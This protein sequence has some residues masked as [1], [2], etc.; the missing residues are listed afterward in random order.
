MHIKVWVPE[1]PVSG[2]VTSDESTSLNFSVLSNT[3]YICAPYGD[4]LA[5]GYRGFSSPSKDS[6]HHKPEYLQRYPS[7]PPALPTLH[8]PFLLARLW[9]RP[10][11]LLPHMPI[12]TAVSFLLSL[13]ELARHNIILDWS[14]LKAKELCLSHPLPLWT[15]DPV[16]CFSCVCSVPLRPTRM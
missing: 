4:R 8:I 9:L 12:Q 6:L 3:N 2:G 16:L 11:P 13:C 14:S 10:L 7:T 15:P 5:K 1:S